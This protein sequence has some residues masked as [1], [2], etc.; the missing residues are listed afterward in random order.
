MRKPGG[1]LAL[2]L[3]HEMVATT[4]RS[5]LTNTGI[6]AQSKLPGQAPAQGGGGLKNQARG[7]G[8]AFESGW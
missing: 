8:L 2:E 6:S 4:A 5:N 3:I 7:T 1:W